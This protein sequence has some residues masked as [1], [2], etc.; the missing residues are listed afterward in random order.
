M[1]KRPLTQMLMIGGV[2]IV[3]GIPLALAIPW[4]PTG[5][6]LQA[7]NTRTLYDVLLIV[8]VPIFV[9]VE[10]VVLYSVWKFRMKPGEE[11]KDGP[12]IHGNT[13]LEVVWTA[14]P[15]IVLVSLSTY[16]Y[17]VLH[18][19][20]N[21]R[22]GEMV[23]NVTERQFAFEF[24]Y[25][26]SAGKQVVTPELYLPQGQ[27]V[28]FHIRS[29]DVIHSFFVPNFSE[30]LDAVPGITTTLRVVPT[31]LGTYPAECT[32]LCGA[33]HSLMR[34]TVRVVTPAAFKTWISRQKVNGPPPVGSP[35]ANA[36]QPGVPGGSG[37]SAGSSSSS[38]AP[39]GRS[40]SSSAAA[41]SGTRTAAAANGASSAAAATGKAVFASAACGSC[42]T[43]AAAG[44]NGTVGP[45]L[46]TRLRSDCAT[47][48]SQRIRGAT[49]AQC[50]HT[51]IVRP[52]AYLP[53][54]YQANIMPPTF[55]AT[56]GPTKAQALVTY[57]A[58]VTK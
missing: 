2:A 7:S 41:G 40:G 34:A 53:A 33:G 28:V 18:S 25:P 24:S 49:L 19:N 48:A 55:A 9:L 39:A 47:A 36:D 16:A 42:H 31:V 6:S 5:G 22:R 13:R 52:Y 11:E 38:S 8:S 1:P 3:I 50:I 43:L 26:Q 4:F 51:A 27:P 14:L 46:T 44:T 32:E 45:D 17:T 56:L 35:P 23:V 57:I 15:A 21:S 54:G 30:K 12:P 10:T 29:L 20:E 37:S 58:S